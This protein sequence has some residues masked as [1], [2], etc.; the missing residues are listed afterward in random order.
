MCGRGGLTLE[1]VWSEQKRFPETENID[2][3]PGKP[4]H[5]IMFIFS[6]FR[7]SSVGGCSGTI[8]SPTFTER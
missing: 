4:F 1:T 6:S 7:Q 2:R 5:T 8:D 3:F